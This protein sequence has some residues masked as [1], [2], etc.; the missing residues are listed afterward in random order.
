MDF[1]LLIDSQ[2]YNIEE[3]RSLKSDKPTQWY[4]RSCGVRLGTLSR[5]EL[6]ASLAQRLLR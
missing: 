2:E 5:A 6:L 4:R 3:L 1:V